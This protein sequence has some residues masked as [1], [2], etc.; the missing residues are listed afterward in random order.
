MTEYRM[1]YSRYKRSYAD[2]DTLRGS[3]RADSKSIVVLIPDGRMK[4][5]GV[6]GER[7]LTIF[8]DVGSDPEHTFRQGF[9]S[10][11][12]TNAVKQAKRSYKYVKDPT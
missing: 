6:R 4:S 5:S 10:I 2:C 1:P 8:L 3:Y 9:R 7:F 12:F 11:C